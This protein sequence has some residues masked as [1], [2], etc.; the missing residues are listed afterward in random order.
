VVTHG[1]L[2]ID[3]PAGL[4]S[5]AV[6]AR[7]KRLLGGAAVG[8]TGTLDPLATGVL[9]IVVGEGTKLAA[10]LLADDKEYDAELEL[11]VTTDT[12]DS[13]G[14]V[15]ARADPSGVTESALRAALASLIGDQQQLPPMFSAIKQDGKRLYDLARQGKEVDRE[16]RAIHIDALTLQSF[17]PPRARFHVACSKGTYVRA[18]VRDLGAALGCGAM[19]TALRRTRAGRFTLAHA[20]PLDDSLTP[21][22]ITA[23][24]VPPPEAIAHLPAI[25]LDAAGVTIVKH[26]KPPPSPPG[27]HR[28]LTP[29]GALAAVVDGPT[30][31]RVFNYGLTA[32]GP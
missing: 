19:L 20:L 28:L 5:A 15:T 11:G 30:Y 27:I 6:V 31:L 24:L 21:D 9:P 10:F 8:H 13:D 7:V 14:Q 22:K 12:L 32:K 25:R 23:A 4:T 2:V 26:G 18:I 29:E 17:T 16:L 1:V 3:K